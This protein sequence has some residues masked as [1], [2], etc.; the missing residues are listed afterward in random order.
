M[1]LV[2]MAALIFVLKPSSGARFLVLD[3]NGV[4]LDETSSE[5]VVV[6]GAARAARGTTRPVTA[7]VARTC[8]SC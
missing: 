3:R 7:A 4:W 2:L 6:R 5:S 8:P 1:W